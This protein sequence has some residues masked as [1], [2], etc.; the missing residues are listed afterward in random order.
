MKF[1]FSISVVMPAFN[2]AENLPDAIQKCVE[3]LS[4]LTNQYEVI[5]IDDYST[6]KTPEVLVNLKKIYPYLKTIRNKK[7]LGCHPSTLVGFKAATGKV[8]VFLPADQQ[9]PP[10]NIL[11]FLSKIDN[12]DLVCSYRRH[13]VDTLPRHL[14]S[15]LYN[16]ILRLCFGVSLHDTH[17]AIAVKKEV[18]QAIVNDVQSPSAFAGCELILRTLMRRFR[19]TEIEIDHSPRIA[20]KAKGANLRDAVLTPVNLLQLLWELRRGIVKT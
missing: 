9:I 11:Q 8:L 4:T 5:V 19:V 3:A 2:E 10:S 20:G 16:T 1:P 7:N 13:R 17:S 12:Y 18:I 14:A 15:R 6:D